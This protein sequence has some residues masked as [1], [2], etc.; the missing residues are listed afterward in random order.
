M[1]YLFG[2]F[3]LK[4]ERNHNNLLICGILEGIAGA[5]CSSGQSDRVSRKLA[6]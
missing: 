6:T 1:I 4:F 2:Q 5:E 3:V